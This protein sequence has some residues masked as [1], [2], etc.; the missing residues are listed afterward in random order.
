MSQR[1]N[2][3]M[4]REHWQSLAV[5]AQEE[6][7]AEAR[8][9]EFR[10]GTDELEVDGVSRRNFL[11]IMGGSMALAGLTTTGCWRK[12]VEYILPFSERPEDLIPG[13]PLFYRTAMLSGQGVLGLHV[14]SHEGRPTKIEGN[15]DHP[16]TNPKDRFN[17]GPIRTGATNVWAQASV[18]DLYDPER[19]QTPMHRDGESSEQAAA[20]WSEFWAAVSGDEGPFGARGRGLGV[21]VDSTPSPSFRRVLADFRRVYPD[22]R[23]YIDDPITTEQRDAGAAMVGADDHTILYNLDEARVIVSLDADFLGTEGD[24]VRNAALFSQGRRVIENQPEMSRLYVAEPNLTITGVNADNRLRLAARQVGTLM[25]AIAARVVGEDTS[26]PYALREQLQISVGGEIERW[27]EAIAEDLR[28]NRNHTAVLVGQRQPAWVHALGYLVNQTL[29]NTG[30]TVRYVADPDRPSGDSLADLASDIGSGDIDCLVILGG[31]PVYASGADLDFA[32]LLGRVETVIHQGYYYDQTAQLATWHVPQSH[33][34]ESWG[35]LR[36]SDG[37][38]SIQQPLIAPLFDTHS[39][40]DLLARWVLAT[41]RSGWDVEESFPADHDLGYQLV[42]TFSD[43]PDD[44]RWRRW[45]HDGITDIDRP[46]ERSP[47]FVWSEL[48]AA[49]PPAVAA[50]APTLRSGGLEL[51]IVPDNSTF[52][53]RYATNGWLVEVPDPVTK[54]SWDNAALVSPAT[55]ESLGVENRDLVE[56]SV[57]GRSLRTALWVVPGMADGVVTVSLGYGHQGR[58]WVA[59]GNGFNAY[60]LRTSVAP[61]TAANASVAPT[62]DR[63]ELANTQDYSLMHSTTARTGEPRPLVREATLAHYREDPGFVKAYELLDERQI[64][65]LFHEEHVHQ[66]REGQQWGM[67]I[68]LNSCIGCNACVV[69]CVSE[70]N[71]MVAGR[72][73]VRDGRELHWLRIDRYFTGSEDNPQVVNQPLPCQQCENAPCETVCPVG[74]TTH[75]PDGLNDMAYNRC[76]GTR[77]CSNNCPYKVRRFNYFNFTKENDDRGELTRM[78]RNPNV[79]LRFR[80]VME[81]C[82]Y[83]VQRINSAKHEN[84]VAGND[85]VPDG[86]IIPACAQACPTQAILFGDIMDEESVVALS[87]ADSRDYTILAELNNTPRTSYGGKLRNPNPELA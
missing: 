55:A 9:R 16:M 63:Y 26:V 35:D 79:T 84:H 2:E 20:D 8:H 23:I 66:R 29:G 56:V 22:A 1:L 48:G 52:D 4:K 74:A 67:S 78:V 53:G 31:N 11:G 70:N 43:A 40:L 71:I 38:V 13:K 81:K 69:A 21:L 37:T 34:L 3:L 72:E 83:C 59:D 75:S 64:Q 32:E 58:G 39:S 7:A 25:R 62:G 85:A 45:L 47:S 17:R 10:P 77:Y 28:A 76:I 73:R 46:R 15:P 65:S 80:G 33:Y 87:K 24:V 41:G 44:R 19:S 54:I 30:N 49:L 42:R 51:N 18:L 61:W 50:T 27:A 36:S 5:L 14:E 57:N 12:P 86:Q 68:D 60:E 6:A 82:T